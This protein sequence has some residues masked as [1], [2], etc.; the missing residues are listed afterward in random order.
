MTVSAVRTD[1]EFSL[2]LFNCDLNG[3][4]EYYTATIRL[5]KGH[6]HIKYKKPLTVNAVSG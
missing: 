2:D 6:F 3:Y 1:V 4:R 5:R